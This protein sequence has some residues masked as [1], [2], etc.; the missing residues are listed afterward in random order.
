VVL[1][2]YWR[3]TVYCWPTLQR[4]RAFTLIELLVVVSIISLL[5]AILL[6]SLSRA[7]DQA[8]SV[9][10]LARLKDFGTGLAAYENLNGDFLPPAEWYPDAENYALL[11]YGWAE[12]LFSFVHKEPPPF[13]ELHDPPTCPANFPAQRNVDPRRFDDYFV[14]K[15]SSRQAANSG[16]YR[17]YLPFWSGAR[18]L[19]DDQGKL[20]GGPVP[21]VGVSRPSLSPKV[22]LIGDANE[23]S[24]RGDGD[25]PPGESC[26]LG[27]DCSY[28]NAGE[29]NIAGSNGVDGNRF[30]DRHDGGA[31]YL[32]QDFH[33]EWNTHLRDELAVDW[34]LNGVDDIDVAP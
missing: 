16:S 32:F 34:D 2:L 28:I 6:P 21:D 31:N 12:L 23:L 14:C 1:F 3:P 26:A 17:V 33:A 4:L 29:A 5:V 11:R 25:Y 19:L 8:K 13:F 15:A 10:C 18:H 22:P 7:R 27:D 24:H 30:S 20:L 9:S